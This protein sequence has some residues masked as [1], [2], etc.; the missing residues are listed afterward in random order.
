MR[1][2]FLTNLI[3]AIAAG[4][5]VVASQAFT[6]FVAG[7]LAFAVAAGILVILGVAQLD[8]RRGVIQRSLDGAAGALAIW[9]IVASLVFTVGTVA[10]LTFAAA[11]G[12]AA[13]AAI[14][15][16]ANELNTERVVHEL[17]VERPERETPKEYAA[18]A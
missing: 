2:R 13:V 9:T 1:L 3:M 8:S 4:F 6:G 5:L 11:L 17:S 14:G 15:L 12:F 18:A 16:V 7:W 10:S